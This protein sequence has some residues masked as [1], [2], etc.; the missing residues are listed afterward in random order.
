MTKG[1]KVS[2]VEVLKI[3][4]DTGK[5][6]GSNFNFRLKKSIKTCKLNADLDFLTAGVTI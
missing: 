1:D 4:G 2:A 6:T 5:S 3:S